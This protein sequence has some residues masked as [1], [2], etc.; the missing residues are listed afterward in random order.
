[1]APKS[2]GQ[3]N[4]AA[5]EDMPDVALIRKDEIAEF[6]EYVLDGLIVRPSRAYYV[7]PAG[8]NI[9]GALC[10]FVKYAL[11]EDLEVVGVPAP[12]RQFFHQWETTCQA[13]YPEIGR[14]LGSLHEML[15]AELLEA[16][17]NAP[18]VIELIEWGIGAFRTRLVSVESVYGDYSPATSEPRWWKRQAPGLEEAIRNL[19]RF[20]AA[21]VQSATLNT[22]LR[23]VEEAVAELRRLNSSNLSDSLLAA[24]AYCFAAAETSAERQEYL[25]AT[26]LWH[27]CLDFFLQAICVDSGIVIDTVAGLRFVDRASKDK[28]GLASCYLALERES[29]YPR[30]KALRE[31]ILRANEIRNNL[32]STHSIYGVSQKHYADYRKFARGVLMRLDPGKARGVEQRAVRIS[33]TARVDPK[34]LFALDTDLGLCVQEV[35]LAS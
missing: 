1:M 8:D 7:V 4:K 35:V 5:P 15:P 22:F 33:G 2:L 16:A 18:Q 3:W 17:P 9:V 29:V 19:K 23:W 13:G 21:R 28:P 27:R 10:Y 20:D 31:T 34:L 25:V 6:S 32:M 14:R 26:S 30:D 12:L 11:G 24:A